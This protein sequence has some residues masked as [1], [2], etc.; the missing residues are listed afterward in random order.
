MATTIK[1]TTTKS[2][3]LRSPP[4]QTTS[5]RRFAS[6]R[7]NTILMSTRRQGRGRKIQGSLRSQRRSER[8]QEAE[9]LRPGRVLLRQH[10]CRHGRG[11]RP[12]RKRRRRRD[13]PGF[14]R[15]RGWRR[16]GDELR[17]RRFR[18]LRHVRRK[19][20]RKASTSG[21]GSFRDIFSGIFGGRGGAAQ[22]GPDPDPI[23]S[24]RSTSLLDRHPRRRDAPEHYSARFLSAL[25]GHGLSNPQAPAGVR[26]ERSGHANRWPHEI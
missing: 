25:H 18:F 14:S 26:R 19:P 12:R 20:G 4:Q 22:E 21:T 2:W 24:T 23:W 8:S 5:A 11:L 7:A 10:R 1:K 13:W 15:R 9:D 17:F 6:W 3:A 16:A